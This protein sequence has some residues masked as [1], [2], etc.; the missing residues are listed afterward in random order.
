MITVGTQRLDGLT[1]NEPDVQAVRAREQH[2]R[3][4]DREQV[5]GERP[6][7]VHD[8]R[9]ERV[10]PC[11]EEPREQRED[12]RERTADER[13]ADTDLRARRGRRRARG[14]RRPGPGCRRRGS[15]ATPRS[16]RS[17]SR[18]D[19]APPPPCWI[20]SHLLPFR[21]SCRRGSRRTGRCARCRARRSARAKLTATISRKSVSAASAIRLRSRRRPARRQGACPRSP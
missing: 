21:W 15:T 1:V 11:P 10:D 13:G 7:Q 6:D 3:E 5:D 20:T 19:R 2:G 17:A 16:A 18:R 4:R 12:D 14:P 8:P 9:E